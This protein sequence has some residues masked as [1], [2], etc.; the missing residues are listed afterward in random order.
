M[1]QALLEEIAIVPNF[2]DK[3]LAV[4]GQFFKVELLGLTDKVG[5]N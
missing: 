2:N 4:E 3:E 5:T 1:S